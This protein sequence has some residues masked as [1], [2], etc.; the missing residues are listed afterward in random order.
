MLR[1]MIISS[2]AITSCQGKLEA[3]IELVTY[4][5]LRK[6]FSGVTDWSKV[7]TNF[8]REPGFESFHYKVFRL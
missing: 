6:C 2:V 8:V 5:N 7:L 1:Q 3:S 4:F